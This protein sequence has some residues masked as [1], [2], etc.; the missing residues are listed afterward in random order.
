MRVSTYMRFMNGEQAISTAESQ[1]MQ[2]QLQ[3]SSG[4]QINSPSDN[5]IGAANVASLTGTVSQLTQFQSN[6]N[7]AQMQLNQA[8]SAMTSLVNLVTSAQQTLVQAGD[9]SYSDGQRQALVQQLQGDLNQMV[10][11]ANTSDGQGGYLFAGAQQSAPPF[12]Q[13]GNNVTY[14]GDSTLQS[15]QVSQNRQLQ[16][17]FSGDDIFQK[18]R[19]G[20][21]SFVTAAN[22]SNTGSGTIDTG[23]VTNPSALTGDNYAVSFS[24]SGSSTTYQVQD[25][26]TNQTVSSGNYAS[27]ATLAFDGLQVTLSGA[28]ANG[29]SF[30]VA[31]AAYQSIFTTMANAIAALQQPA[32]TPA[33]TAQLQTSVGASLASMSQALDHMTLKQA[34]VGD[35]LQQLNSYSSLNSDRQLQANSTLSSIQDLD[36]AKA[37]S[38]LA[39]QQTT[40]QAALQSY[41]AVSKLS[42]FNYL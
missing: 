42:L 5:P 17:K 37:A 34:E 29:D 4:K 11:L 24:V 9:G 26:T 10:G 27:P 32:D 36:Y 21:G 39:Q 14:G 33:A 8:D 23:A 15:V 2:T 20:N 25:T 16:I 13:L 41:S 18:I 30:T 19:P 7:E 28:P 35:Q 31:P 40:Y 22:S 12:S 38:Q 6:Q 3:L 1:L